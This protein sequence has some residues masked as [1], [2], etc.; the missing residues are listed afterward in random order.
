VRAG[1]ADMRWLVNHVTA[2]TVL[3]IAA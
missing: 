3:R 1:S 2:G